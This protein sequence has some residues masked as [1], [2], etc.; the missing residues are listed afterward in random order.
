MSKLIACK[1]CGAQIAKSAK[2]CPQCGAKNKPSN[3]RVFF[4]TILI[5]AAVFIFAVAT[6]GNSDSEKEILPELITIEEFNEIETGMT[7]D[8]VVKIIGSEGELTSQVDI[9][10]YEFRT[11]LYVWYGLTPGANANVTFQGGKVVAKAQF[12]LI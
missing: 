3:L 6:A 7:Y 10:E 1:A 11:E 12:G 8:E 9:G 4:L 2:V 5:F